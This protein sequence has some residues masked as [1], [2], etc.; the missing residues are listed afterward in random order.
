MEVLLGVAPPN[1]PGDVPPLQ[2]NVENQKA[3]P[4]RE[5][6]E[7]HRRSPACAACHKMMDPIGLSLENFNAVGLWRAH[8]SGAR[9]DPNGEL[10]DGTP[11]DGPVSLR[12][13]LLGRTD[14]FV[15]SFTENFLSYGLGRL[16][17][18]RDMPA[19]RAIQREAEA[20]QYRFSSFVLGVV[21]SIPF[22]MRRADEAVTTID[23]GQ[24]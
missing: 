22:Q 24:R 8:D 20:N 12:Q 19:V 1:P 5:R 9:V 3:L 14:S 6:L 4:V 2:E 21:K 17:D 10:Y 18:H 11:L 16:L 13:A 7:Q 23:R 15:G